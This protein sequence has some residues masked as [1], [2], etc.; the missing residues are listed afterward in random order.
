MSEER[1]CGTFTRAVILFILLVMCA[2]GSRREVVKTSSSSV[3]TASYDSLHCAS[4]LSRLHDF[5]FRLQTDEVMTIDWVIAPDSV[6]VVPARISTATT[7]TGHQTDALAEVRDSVSVSAEETS[8]ERADS[9]TESLRTSASS[10]EETMS[11]RVKRS[12]V[13]LLLA[14]L[15]VALLYLRIT[16]FTRKL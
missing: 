16:D 10:A 7:V 4:V 5:D 14:V 9:L 8:V 13:S 1:L 15:V 6:T 3:A 12:L 2:C 11:S